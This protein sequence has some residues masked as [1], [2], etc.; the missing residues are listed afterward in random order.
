MWVDLLEGEPS[1]IKLGQ[2]VQPQPTATTAA[3]ASVSVAGG[4]HAPGCRKRFQ[5]VDLPSLVPPPRVQLLRL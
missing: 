1:G 2:Q 3:A 4:A 5:M